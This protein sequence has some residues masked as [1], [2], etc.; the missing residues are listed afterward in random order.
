MVLLGPRRPVARTSETAFFGRVEESSP[1][2]AKSYL[3]KEF[4]GNSETSPSLLSV[5]ARVRYGMKVELPAFLVER[6]VLFEI[7][8]VT[9]T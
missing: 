1:D 7:K 2:G 9:R 8:V 6:K 4:G 3:P 5:K